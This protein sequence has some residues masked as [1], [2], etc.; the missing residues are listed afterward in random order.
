MASPLESAVLT[1]RSAVEPAGR[2]DI[3][4]KARRMLR[5]CKS[6]S[7]WKG[8]FQQRLGGLDSQKESYDGN[9]SC[10][11]GIRSAGALTMQRLCHR[12]SNKSR[13]EQLRHNLDL[14]NGQKARF[15]ADPTPELHAQ[16]YRPT[17]CC[18]LQVLSRERLKSACSRWCRRSW[19]SSLRLMP[20]AL[21]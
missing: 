8:S 2:A 18:V 19:K 16:P 12:D 17:A 1:A 11:R 6:W 14:Y 15:A 3:S 4:R 20:K 5:G 7:C 21:T 10:C 13:C 9:S